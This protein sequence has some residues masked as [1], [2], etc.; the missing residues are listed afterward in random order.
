VEALTAVGKK[1][2]IV[3]MPVDKLRAELNK[4]LLA[5]RY[6]TPVGEIAFTPEG[7]VIQKEFYVAKIKMD[8]DGKSGKFAMIK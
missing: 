3:E 4:Q 8:A 5:G 7:D 2:E 1:G 6:E